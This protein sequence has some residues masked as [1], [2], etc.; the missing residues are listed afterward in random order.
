MP[1]NHFIVASRGPH[2]D[3]YI[4]DISKHTSFPD[5]KTPAVLTSPQAICVG[6]ANEGYAMAWSPH[7][8][9]TLL[10]G[11]EDGTV[12]LWDVTEAIASK[13]R[14]N[15]VTA[16]ATFAIHTATVED[17]AWHGKDPHMI[18]SVGDD[19]RICIWDTRKEK[20]PIHNIVKAHEGDI[21]CIAFNP[22]MEYVL[23]TGCAG[24]F[25]TFQY[26]ILGMHLVSHS[27]IFFQILQSLCGIYETCRNQFLNC[28]DI[29]NKCLRW[30]GPRSMK[31]Y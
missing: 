3:I 21:N 27:P 7:Q 12:K 30:N 10:T 20:D 29:R 11:S 24:T 28:W 1:Q 13:T 4:W 8:S 15:Q 5:E 19:Q 25:F 31:V 14:I 16:Q 17:V 26:F 18:G 23:A 6:H 22:F 2:P 9:G